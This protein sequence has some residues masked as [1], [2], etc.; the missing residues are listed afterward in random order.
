MRLDLHKMNDGSFANGKVTF[1]PK[2]SILTTEKG[3][4]KLKYDRWM[5]EWTGTAM[6][7]EVSV[8]ETEDGNAVLEWR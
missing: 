4:Y 7:W 6:D 1:D 3:Q 2:T 8:N 5:Q